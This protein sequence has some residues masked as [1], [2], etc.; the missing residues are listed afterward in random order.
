MKLARFS[1]L[2]LLAVLLLSGCAQEDNAVY[3]L[4]EMHYSGAVAY[5]IYVSYDDNGLVNGYAVSGGL[6][7][8]DYAVSY[9]EDKR[10]IFIEWE[11]Y[12]GSHKTELILD[13]YLRKAEVVSTGKNQV[14]PQRTLY[15]YDEADNLLSE[16]EYLGEEKLRETLFTYKNGICTE[17]CTRIYPDEEW[18]H[19]AET[20]EVYDEKGNLTEYRSKN[21]D[22]NQEAYTC[23]NSYD[24]RGRLIKTVT[25]SQGDAPAQICTYSYDSKGRLK[26]KD[27]GLSRYQY[28]YDKAGNLLSYRQVPVWTQKWE[29]TVSYTYDEHGNMTER[30]IVKTYED[31]K[32]DVTAD[33]FQYVRL[34]LSEENRALFELVY[35]YI[36]SI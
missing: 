27:D 10:H 11:D 35:A 6:Q 9:S 22:G 32:E 12:W 2:I 24:W 1:L 7:E 18:K 4:T 5:E 33:S 15:T 8:A 34:E 26:S 28:T 20:V 3:A 19:I 23:I 16:T 29:K 14:L 25:N 21:A 36:L 30:K 17:K 31:G 13:E